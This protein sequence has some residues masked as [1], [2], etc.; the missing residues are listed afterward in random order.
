MILTDRPSFWPS[1]ARVMEL[2]AG[3]RRS[4]S[5]AWGTAMSRAVWVG[6]CRIV[7]GAVGGW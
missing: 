4:P 6:L 2:A 1:L 7:M 3:A 5:F